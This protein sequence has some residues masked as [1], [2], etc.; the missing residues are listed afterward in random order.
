MQHLFKAW[1]IIRER[2]A[3]AKGLLL[4]TDFDGTISPIVP[5]PKDAVISQ[6]IKDLLSELKDKEDVRVAVISGRS[7]G[8]L[9]GRV[10]LSGVIYAGNHGLEIEAGSKKMTHPGAQ[11]AASSIL[12][13]GRKLALKLSDYP[14]AALE[15][16]G[17]TISLHYRQVKRED[18]AKIK[19]M[20]HE[21][22]EP[23]MASN[24]LKMREGKEVIEFLPALS[25]DKGS[26][27]RW[28][29][30][31]VNLLGYLPIYLGDDLTDEDAFLALEEMGLTA[32]VGEESPKSV[33]EYFLSD[34]GEVELFL[35]GVKEVLDEKGR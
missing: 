21:V 35:G 32:L 3:S 20:A 31:E 6:K 15:E 27:V 1:S 16:K 29:I 28:I 22:C 11:E 7:L 4:L 9:K 34:I 33:A 8:D 13:L 14:D 25:W 18:V 10:G 30:D 23:F 12:D 17:L 26:A 24:R 5:H 2:I 19:R